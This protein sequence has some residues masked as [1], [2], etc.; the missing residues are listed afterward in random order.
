MRRF[1]VAII[2][3]S[4]IIAEGVATLA[5]RSGEFE[6]VYSGG[7][8]RML[9][10]RFAMV[11]PDVVIVGSQMVGANNQSLRVA[12][13]E[14][15]SVTLALL[16][17]T[18]CD[19]EVMRQFDGVVNI[20]DGQA[21]I[22][23][24]LHAAVEQGETNPYSDSHDLSERERDVLILVAK[25]KTNKEIADELNISIHTVMSHRKNITHK[26]GI[27]SVAGLTVYALLNNLLDQNDVT[28]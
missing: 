24:K 26:T 17:T 27:K 1:R 22:I 23:R 7:D 2:E 9:M 5:G 14:L 28:L 11:A 12:Y 3:P 21:Q 4:A 19:E 6:I 10:E 15:Q 25:G 20:Y 16:S 8:M 18:V 13:P